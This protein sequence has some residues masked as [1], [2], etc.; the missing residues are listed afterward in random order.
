MRAPPVNI[1]HTRLRRADDKRRE[2]MRVASNLLRDGIIALL[3][4]R[5]RREQAVRDRNSAARWAIRSG[6]HRDHIMQEYAL[7]AT[8]YEQLAM[9]VRAA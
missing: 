6:G 1:T 9:Q 4:E 2:D 5:H 8:A 3:A 7:S